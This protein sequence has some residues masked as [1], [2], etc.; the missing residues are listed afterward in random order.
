VEV[1]VTSDT[2]HVSAYASV[3]DNTTT[4]RCWS[5]PSIGQ[6][7]R[8]TFRRSRGGGVRHLVLE[9]PYRHAHLHG[10]SSPVDVTLA[11]TGA[12][13]PNKVKTI[14]AG[15]TLAS[16]T[17]CRRCGHHRRRRGSRHDCGQFAARG[18][19]TDVQPR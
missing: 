3:L 17:C 18:H 13:V 1:R 6:D 10:G 19:S 14:G 8:E 4:D 9:L 16:T 15:E 7:L 12:S 11:F 5:S 2:G